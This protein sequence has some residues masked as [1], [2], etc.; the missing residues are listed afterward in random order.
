MDDSTPQ[1]D[2]PPA[3]GAVEVKPPEVVPAEAPATL[4][5]ELVPAEAPPAASL[6]LE[7]VEYRRLPG[8]AS[9]VLALAKDAAARWLPVVKEN[10]KV[11][12]QKALEAS[13]WTLQ[14][15]GTAAAATQEKGKALAEEWTPI[16]KAKGA[17][18]AAQAKVKGAELAAQAR[19]KSKKLLQTLAK[20]SAE[21]SV[22]AGKEVA[23]WWKGPPLEKDLLECLKNAGRSEH[24][25]EV[26]EELRK[27]DADTLEVV[28]F[29]EFSVGKSSLLNALVGRSL[30]HEDVVPSTGQ[31]T[32][33]VQAAE[34][35]VTVRLAD[36]TEVGIDVADLKEFTTLDEQGLTRSDIAEVVIG[37][38]CPLL[39]NGVSLADAPG[40][41]D[42]GSGEGRV[43]QIERTLKAFRHADVV[44]WVCHAA[45]LLRDSELA[46]TEKLVK[47]H[48]YVQLI[49]VINFM[50]ELG[51]KDRGNVR[52][53]AAR[54]L[55]E[56]FPENLMLM[57]QHDADMPPFFEVDAREAQDNPGETCDGFAGLSKLIADLSTSETIRGATY[58]A[59]IRRLQALLNTIQEEVRPAMA[60]HRTEAD[61]QAA[62][63]SERVREAELWL[64][65]FETEA[66]AR[67]TVLDGAVENVSNSH[68]LMVLHHD[69]EGRP[70]KDLPMVAAR[71]GKAK[72]KEA[73]DNAAEATNNILQELASKHG[74][75]TP[76]RLKRGWFEVS[77]SFTHEEAGFWNRTFGGKAYRE[78][79]MQ[80]F[81]RQFRHVWNGAIVALREKIHA[82]WAQSVKTIISHG[83]HHK[84]SV[85]LDGASSKQ[86]LIAIKAREQRLRDGA[87]LSFTERGSSRHGDAQRVLTER[88]ARGE[89]LSEAEL[90][91]ECL[92]A[93]LAAVQKSLPARKRQ[94]IP[95]EAKKGP[96]EPGKGSGDQKKDEAASRNGPPALPNAQPASNLAPHSSPARLVSGAPLP[97]PLP[98]SSKPPPLP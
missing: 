71:R 52:A 76:E 32:R 7:V 11:V 87:Q 66:E 88:T 68:L 40:S 37:I 8:K 27:L 21:I 51:E 92:D 62:V 25:A 60:G 90:N 20:Q 55:S 86:E 65:R 6:K 61:A 94:E 56:R 44:V 45:R 47:Q 89:R 48:P 77:F 14:Q 97:P 42:P 1:N 85:F 67:K 41:F 30:L 13:K 75:P 16:V 43:E 63:H 81:N 15:L 84:V 18:L 78:T 82:H 35:T 69:L 57:K 83:W 17:E 79:Y 58:K 49:P 28:L 95:P 64:R 2:T 38:D 50:G 29:G 59:R 46:L 91:L 10:G 54:L 98:P 34:H 96:P 24:A 70:L 72:L 73:F 4:S 53:R 5:L 23:L 26:L 22:K 31:I 39:R 19:V 33:L 93:A 74:M 36:G 9:K 80:H 3:P 12:G